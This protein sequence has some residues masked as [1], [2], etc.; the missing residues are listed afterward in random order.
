MATQIPEPKPL[1]PDE[2]ARLVEDIFRNP[3]KYSEEAKLILILEEWQHDTHDIEQRCS[4]IHGDALRVT[5]SE[6]VGTQWR[7]WKIALIPKTLPTIASCITKDEGKY[8]ETLFV[9]TKEGWK[10]IKVF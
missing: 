4:V 6:T 7:E 10:K 2:I 8:S 5:L 9:F 1:L 3:E